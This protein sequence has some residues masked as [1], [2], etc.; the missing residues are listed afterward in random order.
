MKTLIFAT[1]YAPNAD[2]WYQSHNTWID[3]VRSSGLHYDQ[4]LI[5]DDHSP[6]IPEISNSVILNQT[7]ILDQQPQS[8]IVIYRFA[9]RLGRPALFIQPGWYRSFT[10]A[11]WYAHK[12]GF[13]RVIHIEADACVI[14]SKLVKY[15]NNYSEGW[16]TLWCPLHGIAETG[17]QVIAGKDCVEAFGLYHYL[18][19]DTHFR[20]RQ[21]DPREGIGSYLPYQV[22]KNFV[23]DRY[24]EFTN[25]VPAGVDYACQ[26]NKNFY[27]WWIGNK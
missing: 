8:Q 19:Y 3:C 4:L 20:G 6:E 1:G 15:F 18:D 9:E 23:G 12:F 25:E 21:P 22:N 10:W 24:S 26:L 13:E 16:E 11:G 27:R 7:D 17:I 2:I 5:P 14:S